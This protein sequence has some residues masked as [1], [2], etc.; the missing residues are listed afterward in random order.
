[1]PGDLVVCCFLK[2]GV[3]GFVVVGVVVQSSSIVVVVGGCCV[4]ACCVDL[5]L[6]D[7]GELLEL[8]S[9]DSSARSS[10]ELDEEFPAMLLAR[11]SVGLSVVDVA[12]CISWV[13][14]SLVV[15]LVG[16][17]ALVVLGILVVLGTLVV[18]GALGVL[19][20]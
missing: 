7:S 1:M 5:T 10:C 16:L 2:L 9:T 11:R 4:V 13:L 15:V 12:V 19:G 6:L 17:E 3:V 20:I 14:I 18:L 8:E